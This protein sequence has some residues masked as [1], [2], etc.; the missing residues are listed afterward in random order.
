MDN[1]HV[2][3]SKKATSMLVAHVAFLAKVSFSAAERLTAEFEKAANSLSSMSQR[4]PWL[5]ADYIPKHQYRFLTFEKRYLI[6]YQVIDKTVYIDHVLDC[7]QDYA[8]L[9]K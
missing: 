2:A 7:R 6:I 1:H 4:N 8:W 3:V 5:I 9:L